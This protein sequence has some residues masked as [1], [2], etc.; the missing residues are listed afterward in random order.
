MKLKEKKNLV[1]KSM[2]EIRAMVQEARK[3]L[4]TMRLDFSQNKLKNT[5][6]LSNKRRDIAQMLS[7][8]HIQE[9]TK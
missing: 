3:E 9:M 7:I 2:T 6:S 8:L 4:L 5:R 1:T